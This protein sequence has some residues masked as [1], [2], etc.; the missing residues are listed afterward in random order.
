M[1][2]PLLLKLPVVPQTDV[3]VLKCSAY[4]FHE[5]EDFLFLKAFPHDLKTHGSAIEQVFMIYAHVSDERHTS[6]R[7]ENSH[8]RKL[9]A[10]ASFRGT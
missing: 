7:L 5:P 6:A 2:D 4:G 3:I 1:I 9:T 10:S 8:V